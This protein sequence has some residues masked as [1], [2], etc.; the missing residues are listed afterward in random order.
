[1]DNDNNWFHGLE[2]HT[3]DR[4]ALHHLGVSLALLCRPHIFNS[5][6]LNILRLITFA[7]VTCANSSCQSRSRLLK[8][9]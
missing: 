8:E 7:V 2:I 9:N 6:S 1:M 5:T 4:D 3:S